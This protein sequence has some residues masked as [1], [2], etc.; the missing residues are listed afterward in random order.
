MQIA[1]MGFGTIGSGVAELLLKNQKSIVAKSGQAS[2]DIKYIL[3]IRDFSNHELGQYFTTNFNDILNDTSVGIVVECM[4]GTE[5][6]YEYVSKCLMAGKSVVSSNKEL[7]AAK[8]YE[9]LELAKEN[10]VNFLFEASVGGGIPIIRP[11]SQCLAA[12]E[13]CEIAGIL[14]GT[15]NFILTMMINEGMTFD[16]ALKLA[17]VNGYAERDPSADILGHDA[18][19]KICILASL[20]FGKHV[21]PDFVETDGITEI[22]S[23]DVAYA[24]NWGGVIK[25]IG[26][27]V[28]NDSGKISATVGPCLIQNHSQLASVDDVFN[29]ILVRGDA[30][31][32]VVF[33]GK[34]AGKLP[35][36]SA[37]VA[38]VI[39]C[40]RHS[41]KRKAFGW[42]PAE[43]NYVI[44]P[45]LQSGALYVRAETDDYITAFNEVNKVF[46]APHILHREDEP[47]TE[48]A[49]VT[50]VMREKEAR[51][52][53][54]KLPID[55]KTV[56][57]V[58]DY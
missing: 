5:P 42:G 45:M 7:V 9:L 14:N 16:A 26:R 56:L 58:L 36:A 1:I 3:D 27:A 6:A 25:L 33:Y 35:T 32:D 53:I 39:D 15:T 12:N 51:A 46:E 2:L 21:Y 4:G 41:T 28:Q 31:G 34:G 57:R 37:V 23:E 13:I 52:S 11:I 29:A 43:D 8:G 10:N 18:A 44:D 24:K 54:E 20:C 49:F 19:R 48:I 50:P 17:Q 38:D 47:K 55:V 22:T 30:I 40:A